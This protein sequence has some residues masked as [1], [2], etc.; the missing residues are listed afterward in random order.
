MKAHLLLAQ[1][2][3]FG[4]EACV[5]PKSR[6]LVFPTGALTFTCPQSLLCQ[7]MQSC[8]TKAIQ[9][10]WEQLAY[11]TKQNTLHTKQNYESNYKSMHYAEVVMG[12]QD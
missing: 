11:F 7:T 3:H 6:V 1:D 10:R 8:V 12:S 9:N 4:L 5:C 2:L